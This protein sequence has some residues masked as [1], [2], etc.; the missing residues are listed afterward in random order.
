MF[1][2]RKKKSFLKDQKDTQCLTETFNHRRGENNLE[3]KSKKGK[4]LLKKKILGKR[5]D[6]SRECVYKHIR[7]KN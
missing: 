1:A 7:K 3:K 2:D 5:E 6:E 4:K